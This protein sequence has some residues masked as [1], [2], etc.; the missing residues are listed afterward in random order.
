[1]MYFKDLS[2]P[3]TS[4]IHETLFHLDIIDLGENDKV[5]NYYNQLPEEIKKYGLRWGF[6]DTAVQ[7]SMHEW[8][9]E[10]IK[11]LL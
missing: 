7:D 9:E 8:F 11:Q 10:N 5:E 1:M 4:G 6:N 3:I 2:K